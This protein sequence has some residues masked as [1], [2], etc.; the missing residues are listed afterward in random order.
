MWYIVDFTGSRKQ[1]P[2]DWLRSRC[3]LRFESMKQESL[4]NRVLVQR[5]EFRSWFLYIPPVKLGDLCCVWAF[6]LSCYPIYFCGLT[7]WLYLFESFPAKRSRLSHN[8][9]ISK[10]FEVGSK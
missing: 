4:S 8:K 5:G 2:K 6:V 7:W 3:S 9:V 10:E 1:I